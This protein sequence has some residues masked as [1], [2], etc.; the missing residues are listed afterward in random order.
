MART[1]FG[2]RRFYAINLTVA[3][4]RDTSFDK[5]NSSAELTRKKCGATCRKICVFLKLCYIP[6]QTT[7]SRRVRK[8]TGIVTF[9]NRRRECPFTRPSFSFDKILRGSIWVEIRNIGRCFLRERCDEVL[10]I[11]R[12][13]RASVQ[14]FR[15]PRK[16]HHRPMLRASFLLTVPLLKRRSCNSSPF[17]SEVPRNILGGPRVQ[18]SRKCK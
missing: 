2:P 18:H 8:A 5:K 10:R 11:G 7:K 14:Y 6:M 9:L 1:N 15:R 4:L 13:V 3:H 12:A 16:S 17:V